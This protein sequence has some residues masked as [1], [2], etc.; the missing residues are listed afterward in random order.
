MQVLEAMISL[1]VLVSFLSAIADG[2]EEKAVNDSLYRYYLA[3]DAWRVLYLRGDFQ[4]FSFSGLNSGRD[5]AEADLQQMG[6]LTNL[7]IFIGGERVT[8]CRGRGIERIASI[9]RITIVDDS[10]QKVML[11]LA[12]KR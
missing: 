4:D 9:E 2:L 7:C 6:K 5:R 11:T 3:N 12:K 1:L 10:P 8:N